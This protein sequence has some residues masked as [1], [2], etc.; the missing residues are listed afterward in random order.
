M[1]LAAAWNP[2]YPNAKVFSLDLMLSVAAN[3][4]VVMSDSDILVTPDLL[5]IVAAEFQDARVR[6][7]T[8]PYRSV[9]GKSICS[10]LEPTD[11][12][13]DFW[14]RILVSRMLERIMFAD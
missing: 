11:L 13:T 7:A 2:P 6:T 14:C 3:D 10:R 9:P 8:C 4:L 12:T 1:C 5:R